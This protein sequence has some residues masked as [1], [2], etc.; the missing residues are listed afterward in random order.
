MTPCQKVNPLESAIT[1]MQKI[2]HFR[3]VL[4]IAVVVTMVN[5][6]FFILSGVASSLGSIPS[7]R[8]GQYRTR[9]GME[10]YGS[11]RMAV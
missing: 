9:A 8:F 5:S 11:D 2:I 6:L 7:L 10:S 4:V 1:M 3:Y